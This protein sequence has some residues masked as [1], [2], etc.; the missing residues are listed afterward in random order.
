MLL[1][2][3][4]AC[5]AVLA[6]VNLSPNASA[7][8]ID[9]FMDAGGSDQGVVVAFSATSG[10]AV[11]RGVGGIVGTHRSVAASSVT[12]NMPGTSGR[13]LE[14]VVRDDGSDAFTLEN[15][16]R[17]KGIGNVKWDS[18]GAG[19][20]GVDITDGGGSPLIAFNYDTDP[21]GEN[22]QVCYTLTLVDT[23]D[24]SFSK[25]ILSAV[26]SNNGA[27]GIFHLN[28]FSA[29]GV[30]LTSINTIMFDVEAKFFGADTNVQFLR[31]TAI[32]E[33]SS[34]VIALTGLG[35]AG[36]YFRR[37]RNQLSA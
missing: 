15:G 17:S 18:N 4:S 13:R 12:Y 2:T 11:V 32:P 26:N 28:L 22:G 29:A 27:V 24:N 7:L 8:L 34:F 9:S 31:S 5:V 36:V 35:I 21:T 1:R 23:L 25:T 37:R 3:V 6:L 10:P 19:L 14:A 30:D 16:T 20:G 33:P